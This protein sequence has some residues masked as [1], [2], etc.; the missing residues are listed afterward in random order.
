MNVNREDKAESRQSGSLVNLE[1]AKLPVGCSETSSIISHK[2]F[3][4]AGA[5]TLFR[6][7]LFRAGP[8]TTQGNIGDN[9]LILEMGADITVR[10]GEIRKGFAP[11]RRVGTSRGDVRRD[12]RASPLPNANTGI[13]K[14]HGIDLKVSP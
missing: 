8:V 1:A 13:A 9:T 5:A 14:F 10:A 11:N 4:A 6:V 3:T 2:C 12:F 7:V